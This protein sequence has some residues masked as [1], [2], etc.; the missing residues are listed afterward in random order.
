V[1]KKGDTFYMFYCAGSQKSNYHYRI[2]MATSKDLK[3]WKRSPTN[4]VFEDFYDARDPMVLLIDRTYYL[5][6]TANL[7]TPSGHHVVN[8]RTSTDLVNWSPAR[9][10]MTH[11]EEGTFGGPTESPF[12]VRYGDHFYLFVG[13]DEDYHGTK[14]YRSPNPYHWNYSDQIYGYPAHA[15]EIVKDYDQKYYATDSGWDLNGVFLAPLT[16][17]EDPK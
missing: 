13:P 1:I 12:V 10:A 4:P 6:Y 7:D 16:W 3:T 9:V 11:P 2:H 5:Y 8:V 14:V 17:K 15:S